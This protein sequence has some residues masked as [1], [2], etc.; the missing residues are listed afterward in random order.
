MMLELMPEKFDVLYSSSS[1]PTSMTSDLLT[2]K[3]KQNSEAFSKRFNKIFK[4][5][6]PYNTQKY[7][8][9]SHTMFSNLLGGIGYF[10]GTSKVDR[11][12]AEAYTEEEEGFWGDAKAAQDAHIQ[13]A[14]NGLINTD[15]GPSELFTSIPS[16]PFFP[17]GFYWDEGFHLLP[18]SQWDMDLTLKIVK[19]WFAL[20][21]EDGWIGREQILGEEARSK[22]PKEFQ[23]QYPHY[24]NPPTLFVILTK[25]ID[26]YEMAQ[27]ASKS[28]KGDFN[29]GSHIEPEDM[30]TMPLRVPKVALKFFHE[31]Y[32]KLHSH[33]Y[34]F[35]KSQ[36]GEVRDWDRQAF[37]TK[38]AYRWRGRTPSLCL[39]SG[40]DDY[41][42]A[43]PPHTGELHVDLLS[44]MGLMTK[45]IR[46]IATTIGEDEDATEFARIEEAMARNVDDLH[47]SEEHQMYC[48]AT[49]DDFYE[50]VHVCHKGYVSILPV[51]LGLVDSNNGKTA[52]VLSLMED[53]EELW[54]EYGLRSLSKSDS[55]FGTGENYWKGP[56]WININYLAI[57]RL[58]VRHLSLTYFSFL[59]Y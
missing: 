36:S 35:R 13:A 28:S 25:Y 38:E 37:S 51:L 18:I 56:V 57:T 59:N 54:S 24:A 34:W 7:L 2:S 53:P 15:E 16:R 19:S 1:A 55:N 40:F 6:A 8:K 3:I 47:W 29:S 49:I 43:L 31:I 50:S 58:Y 21:D 27:A 17:R 26:M 22:V 30:A 4:R 41:P 5:Q 12:N 9:F 42:R 10:Y 48:D 39:T 44:W 33:Y 23:M 32:P 45:C 52:K 20:M 11:S 14:D 46:R